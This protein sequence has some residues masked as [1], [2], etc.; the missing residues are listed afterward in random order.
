MVD[1]TW[2]MDLR[3]G[4]ATLACDTPGINGL[5]MG[6]EFTTSTQSVVMAGLP[7]LPYPSRPVIL[8][9]QKPKTKPQRELLASRS[10]VS[11]TRNPKKH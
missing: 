5:A 7:R 2:E 10:G 11:V 6:H 8:I 1:G 9:A 4:Q 3:E